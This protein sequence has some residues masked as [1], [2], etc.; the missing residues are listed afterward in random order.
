MK[1]EFK[2]VPGFFAI[3][4]ILIAIFFN[5]PLGAMMIV[6]AICWHLFVDGGES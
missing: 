6:G 2:A 1:R 4:G 3:F 5:L